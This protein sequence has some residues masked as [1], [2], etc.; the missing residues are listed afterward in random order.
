MPCTPAVGGWPPLPP[1]AAGLKS[2]LA[3]STLQDGPAPLNG[4]TFLAIVEM[5]I[6]GPPNSH[7][8]GLYPHPLYFVPD[9]LLIVCGPI[10]AG[11]TTMHFIN[12]KNCGDDHN[13]LPMKI[14][15]VSVV[16]MK[17][18]IINHNSINGDGGGKGNGENGNRAW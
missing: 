12:D 7:T 1:A 4:E 3:S 6:R 10:K 11:T 9:Y 18:L 16:V 2:Y 8:Y 17:V 15:T 13:I 14:V 5:V